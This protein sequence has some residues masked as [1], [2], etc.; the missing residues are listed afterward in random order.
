LHWT[1][2][3]HKN[4]NF[5]VTGQRADFCSISAYAR[6]GEEHLEQALVFFL[7]P[8]LHSSFGLIYRRS[9]EPQILTLLPHSLR[10]PMQK[11]RP[12]K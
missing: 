6:A 9:Q 5:E 10:T 12:V 11:F 1:R 2:I 7:L 4:A 8:P 3:L